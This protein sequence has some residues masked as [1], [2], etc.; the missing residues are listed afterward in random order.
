MSKHEKMKTYPRVVELLKKEAEKLGGNQP[1]SV[2][3]GID[4]TSYAHYLDGSREPM[5]KTLMHIA[6][7][8]N[9]NVAWLR[10]ETDIYPNNPK[11]PLTAEKQILWEM[12]QKMTD[13]EALELVLEYRRRKRDQG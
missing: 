8:F 5:T 3:M 9:T 1:A 4:R 7:Y 2:K 13:D 12:V 6:A 10:G 11:D